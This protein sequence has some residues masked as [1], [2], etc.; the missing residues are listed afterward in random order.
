M[1]KSE[2]VPELESPNDEYKDDAGN[3]QPGCDRNYQHYEYLR[4]LPMPVLHDSCLIY[5]ESKMTM[6]TF[7]L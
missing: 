1:V 5:T 2:R 3:H 6:N 4:R 7:F